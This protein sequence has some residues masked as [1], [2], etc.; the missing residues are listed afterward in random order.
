MKGV[1]QNPQALEFLKPDHS[2]NQSATEALCFQTSMLALD[3]CIRHKL[4]GVQILL[5]FDTA[6]P[7]VV[8]TVDEHWSRLGG[9]VN[10]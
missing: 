3:Y 9:D 2:W 8:L 6:T 5:R 4:N 1:I 7:D 10:K